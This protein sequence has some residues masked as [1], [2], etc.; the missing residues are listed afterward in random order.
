MRHEYAHP[1]VILLL[2][3]HLTAD[4]AEAK[5]W[6]KESRFFTCEATDI[7]EALEDISDFTTPR[8]PDVVLIEVGSLSD[9]FS[10]VNEMVRTSSDETMCPIFALSNTGKVVNQKECFEGNLGQLTAELNKMIPHFARAA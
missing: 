3:E 8:R 10:L 1:T 5:E 9:D 6:L 2:D 7:F 4:N